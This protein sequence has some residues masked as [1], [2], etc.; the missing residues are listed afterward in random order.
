MIFNLEKA[1]RTNSL[2]FFQWCKEKLFFICLI[3]HLFFG[4]TLNSADP[5][6]ELA[7]NAADVNRVRCSVLLCKFLK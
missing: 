6:N 4:P 5:A 2:H 7:G 3:F 1:M